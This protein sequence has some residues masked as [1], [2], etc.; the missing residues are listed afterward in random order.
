MLILKIGPAKEKVSEIYVAFIPEIDV[1]CN[2]ELERLGISGR[3]HTRGLPSMNLL[4]LDSDIA[5]MEDP[6]SFTDAFLYYIALFTLK[7]LIRQMHN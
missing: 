5:S 7:Y 6:G 3:I 1:I 4:S 2:N